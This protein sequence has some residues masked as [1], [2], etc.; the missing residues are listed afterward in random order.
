[1]DIR[2]LAVCITGPTATGKT[3]AAIAV[4]QSL[5]GEVLSMDS[6]QIYQRMT[7]GTAAPTVDEMGDIPHH[8]FGY[9]D[10]ACE[11]SVAE[12]QKDALKTLDDVLAR[13]RLPVFCGGTGLYLQSISRPL[14]FSQQAGESDVRERLHREL[15][16]PG[17]TQKLYK[18]LAVVD[19]MSASRLHMNNT[20]RVIR[21]LEV[22]EL[23]GQSMSSRENEWEGETDRDWLIYALRWQRETLAR[24]IDERVERMFAQGLVDEVASL[25][26]SG[27]LPDA[28]AMQA[29]GY[30]EVVVMLRGDCSLQEAMEA[31]KI[32]TRQ[33]A[34][35]QITWLQRDPRVQWIDLSEYPNSQVMHA[36]IIKDIVRYQEK[37]NAKHS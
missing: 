30:K 14:R 31:I 26:R 6:M 32:H 12:Y 24:R 4:C 20:R 13:D 21:A 1:M 15:D 17:G 3:G 37:K 33:Y 9:V 35:R 36:A 5:R 7:I 27:V 28:R 25:L 34:K 11:Y 23:T 29:I 18:R 19:P 22:Y 8:L 10:P 16:E 2:P